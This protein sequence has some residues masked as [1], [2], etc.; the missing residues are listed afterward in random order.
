MTIPN[1]FLCGL[2]YVSIPFSSKN[3][4]AC[5]LVLCL[6]GLNKALPHFGYVEIS[7]GIIISI[8]FVR[9][10]YSIIKLILNH[11]GDIRCYLSWMLEIQTR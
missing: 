11:G 8:G 5:H 9:L 6:S 10:P 3:T 1:A 7:R 2:D 4:L